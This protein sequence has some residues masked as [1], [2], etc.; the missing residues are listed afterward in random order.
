MLRR[1]LSRR[2][3]LLGLLL[4]MGSALG[5]STKAIFVKLSYQ[6]GVDAVTL[7]ALRMSFS[8][9]VFLAAAVHGYWSRQQP[10][11]RARD[12]GLVFLLGFCGYYLSSLFDFLGLQY[13]SASMERLVLFL[14]P[15]LVLAL[16][17]LWLGRRCGFKEICALA[18]SYSG[19]AVVFASDVEIQAEHFWL[20]VGL[21]FASTISYA[22]FLIGAG[23]SI[24][25]IGAARFTAL[26]MTVA[27]GFVLLQFALTH[28]W[29]DLLTRP[30]VY[31]YGFGMAMLATVAP[32]FMLAAAIRRIGSAH[33]SLVGML[34]PVATLLMAHWILGEALT[35]PQLAG[36]AL[37]LAGVLQLGRR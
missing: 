36:A 23:Q 13:I 31:R 22:L 30:E 15:T 35:F 2:Q 37:V 29:R 19:I 4:A 6:Y 12:Y 10:A 28:P 27:C 34:G 1:N 33:T 32:V 26:G 21:V 16:S 5:F 18:L 9:P 24:A 8:L 17:A 14:Y 11:L 7:L 3:Y 25:R 20:G